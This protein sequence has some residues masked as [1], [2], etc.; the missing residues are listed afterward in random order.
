MSQTDMQIVRENVLGMEASGVV[1]KSSSQWISEPVLVVRKDCD[2]RFCIDYRPLNEVT[3]KDQYPMPLIAEVLDCLGPS[4]LFS[5]VDL[6]VR[7]W[8]VV[9]EPSDRYKTAFCTR[10]GLSEFLVMPFGL[11]SAPATFQRLMDSV[12]HDL[13]W[14]TVMVY[15]TDIVILTKT[16]EEHLAVLNNVLQRLRAAGLKASLGK[17]AFGQEELLYLGHLVT[18]EGILPDPAN[19]LPNM[20][21]L[22]PLNI[23]AVQSFLGMT[24]YY[25]D[26]I[27]WHAAIAAPLYALT[28][29]VT[30]FEW[31][32][33]QQAA[34]DALKGALTAP[35]VLR[36]PDPTQPY[37]LHT[38]WS[39]IAIGAVLSQIGL[40]D[41]E[42]HPI[43]CDSRLLHG[44][45]LNYPATEGECL[46]VVHFVE[47][48][49]ASLRGSKFEFEVDHYALKWLMN[50]VHTGKLARWS[51]KLAGYDFTV[52]H[53]PGKLHGSADAMSRAPI[54]TE[55]VAF[56]ATALKRSAPTA[57][58]EDDY[59]ITYAD[60]DDISSD[61]TEASDGDA[62]GPLGGH[63]WAQLSPR[64][65]CCQ[66]HLLSLIC[67]V[68]P[69]GKQMSWCCVMAA[70]MASTQPPVPAVPEGYWLCDACTS[71]IGRDIT[72]DRVTLHFLATSKL[73][74]AG[75]KTESKGQQIQFGR[76]PTAPHSDRQ[77]S[78]CYCRPSTAHP[79]LSWHWPL[80]HCQDLAHHPKPLLVA[81]YDR[82]GESCH[83]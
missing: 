65:F 13:L 29:Q 20:N 38:D 4:M 76:W 6:K 18:K 15:L 36:R 37:L 21:A 26:F 24:K 2:I 75:D 32:E 25:A 73:P 14:K 55:A 72:E 67:L 27:Q 35:P 50:S 31:T 39:P 16:W 51:I 61:A 63:A 59:H 56:I 46:A 47:N 11:T 43:T 54:A 77:A 45:E 10:N 60:F 30:T 9:V 62:L 70:S 44:S 1:V 81:W 22:P 58:S 19:I 69:V 52:K 57:D 17:C 80:W 33:Q 79:G 64:S 5:K 53:R 83:A 40:E 3:V 28:R 82:A 74:P 8:Q 48:W 23:T 68:M 71:S 7:Y 34:F 41:E 78:P 42:E 12:L 49:R 66:C